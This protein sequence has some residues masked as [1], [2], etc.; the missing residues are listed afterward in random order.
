[1]SDAHVFIYGNDMRS[2]PGRRVLEPFEAQRFHAEANG[3]LYA[4]SASFPVAVLDESAESTVIG[5]L[6]QLRPGT[7][8]VVLSTLASSHGYFKEGDPR[9]L[10]ELKRIKVRFFG[11]EEIDD[12]YAFVAPNSFSTKGVECVPSGDWRLYRETL[13]DKLYQSRMTG[14]ATNQPAAQTNVG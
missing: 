7:L 9:N 1:M 10:F 12:V 8:Q 3:V 4:S 11:G 2:M 6:V 13:A 14:S 5:E